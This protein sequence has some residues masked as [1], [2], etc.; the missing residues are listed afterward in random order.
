MKSN[1]LLLIFLCIILFLI[2]YNL[3]KNDNYN[4]KDY[5]NSKDYDNNNYFEHFGILKKI[6]KKKRN[7]ENFKDTKEKYN[8]TNSL[9]YHKSIR[10]L[11][12]KKTGTT[13][14]DILKSS[15]EINPEKLTIE[16]MKNEL[17]KYY[18]SFN[19]EK[20][21][22]NSKDTRESFEKFALY[23]EKFFELFK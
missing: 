13:F 4:Y 17:N 22:N 21:K 1:T 8:N 2:A 14:E 18:Q 20:F 3:Y 16:S 19:K 9:K 15:E 7:K 23:K 5:D 6:K 12:S 10:N 11:K